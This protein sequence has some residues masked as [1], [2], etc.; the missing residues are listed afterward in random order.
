MHTP[1][2][3]FAQMDDISKQS[4]ADKSKIVTEE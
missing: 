2:I 3:R 1:E 4:T